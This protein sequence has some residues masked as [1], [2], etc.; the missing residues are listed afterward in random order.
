MPKATRVVREGKGVARD[1]K[2]GNLIGGV[3]PPW[4]KVPSATYLTD[5][6][7]DCGSPYDTKVPYSAERL[8]T[9]YGSNENYARRYE[10]AKQ[11]SIKEGYLLPEDAARIEPVASP[12]DF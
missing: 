1:P 6:E 7:T 11:E 12:S 9:L 10:E 8:K 3:R 5:Y 2:T 4:I